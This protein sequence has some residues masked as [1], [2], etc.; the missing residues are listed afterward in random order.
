MTNEK[1]GGHGDVR[2]PLGAIDM[3]LWDIVAKI[4]GQ[5]LYRV[6]ADRPPSGE[7]DP[8]VSSSTRPAV[9]TIRVRPAGLR[10]RCAAT[11]I[12]ATRR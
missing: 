3:A 4:A 9:T 5:P 12:S 11:S 7:A 1:P 8:N 10:R 2:R 6:L